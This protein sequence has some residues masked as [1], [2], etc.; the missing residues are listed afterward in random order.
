MKTLAL[1][2]GLKTARIA[3]AVKEQI[4]F[5]NNP[6]RLRRFQTMKQHIATHA[7]LFLGLLNLAQTRAQ[8]AVSA[9]TKLNV[10]RDLPYAAPADPR[11]KVDVYAPEGAKNLP[12]VFWLE[13]GGTH[14]RHRQGLCPGGRRHL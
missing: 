7:I 8:S 6:K 13:G 11:Q 9:Q 14:P 12:V 2:I 4:P 3:T 5:R 1:F 10:T